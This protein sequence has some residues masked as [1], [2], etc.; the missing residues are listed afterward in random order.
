VQDLELP[1]NV[2]C[3]L[4]L[5]ESSKVA[6]EE[7]QKLESVRAPVECGVEHVHGGGEIA[8]VG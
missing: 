1:L 6:S 4:V 7:L 8:A 3:P 2:G 5:A